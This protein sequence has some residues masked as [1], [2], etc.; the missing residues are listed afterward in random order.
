MLSDKQMRCLASGLVRE[1]LKM[2]ESW[3]FDKAPDSEAA[4][5]VSLSP[6]TFEI[7]QRELRDD[8]AADRCYR[9]FPALDIL[10]ARQSIIQIA[11]GSNE[12]NA[13]ARHLAIALLQMLDVE[14]ERRK[15]NYTNPF[16]K[17]RYD[18]TDTP[19]TNKTAPP[20][21]PTVASPLI[22]EIIA[23]YIEEKKTDSW[24]AKTQ[25]QN[26]YSLSLM[27]EIIG[28]HLVSSV[29]HQHMLNLRDTLKHLPANRNKAS[30]YRGKSID[31]VLR[32]KNIKPMAVTT[33][34]NILARIAS[35]WHW[36]EIHEYVEKSPARHLSLPTSKRAD[37]E[38][39][40]YTLDEIQRLLDAVAEQAHSSAHP[41]RVWILLIAMF[42]GMRPNEI[43]QLYLD[44]VVTEGGVRCFRVNDTHPDQKVKNKRARRLVPI[45]PILLEFG[46]ERYLKSVS[47]NRTER[48]F[49]KLKSHRDGYHAYFGRWLQ[50]VNRDCVTKDRTK[51]FY[52]LRHNAITA[53]KQAEVDYTVIAEIVGHTVPG[54]TMGRYGKAQKPQVLLDAL[55]KI[56][57]PVDMT[58]IREAANQTF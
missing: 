36:A 34:N 39:S 23:A 15:G 46:F 38:R 24:D 29:T 51:T 22:S 13:L 33:V 26:Q 2:F 35:F 52:S 56:A 28:D 49:P 54:E 4:A 21:Q 50:D 40:T 14:E 47:R 17:S 10:L 16:D 8:I 11:K 42:S 27:V 30:H 41:E 3:R 7:M 6:D 20:E 25:Q 1:G 31:T 53:L 57:Y 55:K 19:A 32:L 12:Y 43:G 45:H 9:I 44:D 5:M 58:K 48:L 18:I 37:E